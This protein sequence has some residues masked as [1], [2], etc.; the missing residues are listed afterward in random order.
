MGIHN[1]RRQISISIEADLYINST[2]NAIS[3]SIEAD[4]YIKS[5]I[6]AISISIEA[7]LYISSTIKA[8]DHA[9]KPHLVIAVAHELAHNFIQVKVPGLS[10]ETHQSLQAPDALILYSR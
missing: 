7:D 8:P 1:P 10:H 4:L 6:N 5:T 3:I 2:I 9:D